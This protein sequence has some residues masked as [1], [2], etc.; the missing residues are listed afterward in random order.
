[1]RYMPIARAPVTIAGNASGTAATA[2]LIDHRSISTIGRLLNDY[3]YDAD[4]CCDG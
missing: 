3:A 2:K 1:M 4:A